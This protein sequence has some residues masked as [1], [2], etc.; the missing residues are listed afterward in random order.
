MRCRDY[1]D[2]LPGE[3][4]QELKRCK[5]IG[6][7]GL[8]V[9]NIYLPAA[10]SLG[11]TVTYVPDYRLRRFYDWLWRCSLRWRGRSRSPTSWCS[12]AA[13][14]L[15]IVPLHRLEGRVGPSASATSARSARRP[16]ASGLQVITH[17]PDARRNI[18]PRRRYGLR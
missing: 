15:P 4:L 3:L 17:D 6:R 14:T 12:P 8:G 11:I 2:Q 9:Y 10:A 13:C 5:V 16:S 1:Y 18:L 7:F